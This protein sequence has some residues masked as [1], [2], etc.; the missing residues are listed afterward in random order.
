[1]IRNFVVVQDT[2]GNVAFSLTETPASLRFTSSAIG[3]DCQ[4]NPLQLSYSNEIRWKHPC[5]RNVF[6][7]DT[8]R[9]FFADEE[10]AHAPLGTG[11]HCSRFGRVVSWNMGAIWI[12][13]QAGDR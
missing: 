8:S 10:A 13:G 6:L 11:G 1:M 7:Q 5:E 2:T 3:I 12:R 4:K 9:K